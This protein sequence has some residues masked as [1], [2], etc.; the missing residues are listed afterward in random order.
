MRFND[1]DNDVDSW[2]SRSFAVY[3]GANN[4]DRVVD[5][6]LS[7]YVDGPSNASITQY[8]SEVVYV[9]RQRLFVLF[10]CVRRG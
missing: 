7:V 3:N 5:D 9:N 1:V 2:A 8:D 10:G 6:S 4:H